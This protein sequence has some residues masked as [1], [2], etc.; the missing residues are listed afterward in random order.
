[1]QHKK[2]MIVGNGIAGHA[3]ALQIRKDDPEGAIFMVS[4]EPH[5]T[6]Y[7][8]KLTEM[9]DHPLQDKDVF[10]MTEEAAKDA[11]IEMQLSTGVDAVDPKKKTVT[12]DS[13]EV[14]AYD[15]LLLATG[16][17]PFIPTTEG[18][19]LKNVES[20]RTLEDLRHM[21]EDFREIDQVVVIGGGL[22]GLEAA[23]ALRRLGKTVHVVEMAPWLLPRQL[24]EPSSAILTQQLEEEGLVIHTKNSVTEILGDEYV[25]GVRLQDGEEIAAEGVLFNIG[26]RPNIDLARLTGLQVDRGVVVDEHMQTNI[27]DIYAA[28]DCIQYNGMCFGL[29]TQSNAMGKVAGA[30]MAGGDLTY[31][32]PKLFS[33]LKLGEIRLFSSGDVQNFDEMH[34]FQAEGKDFKK[35]FFREGK[36]V[37]AIL[38]GDTKSMGMV[39]RMLD[40]DIAFEEYKE[41]HIQ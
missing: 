11:R 16:A 23:Y 15:K 10:L 14:Y 41:K 1:M 6:Y 26:V 17:D 30:N 35:F 24:D 28:G 27:D 12:L 37:G 4:K 5:H 13:G 3:A 40:G 9:I 7:R 31:A 36:P 20:L 39:N 29:W 34:E 25:T 21:Q 32:K 38:Y 19:H 8:L 22:L 18:Q 33:S 2:Y